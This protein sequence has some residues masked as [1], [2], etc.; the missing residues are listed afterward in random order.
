MLTLLRAIALAFL[1]VS[2]GCSPASS[3]EVNG[4]ASILDGDTLDIG[5]QRIRLFGIDAPETGQR[6]DDGKGKH[7]P[8]GAEA[9]KAL[10]SMTQGK[11]LRCEGDTRDTYGRLLARCSVA[12]VSINEEMIRQGMAWAFVKYSTDFVA[13]EADAKQARVGI[14]KAATPTAWEYRASRWKVAEVA[15]PNGCPI[16]G[17]VNSNGERIYH[18]PWSPWYEKV[19]MKDTG[20]GKRWFCSEE[21]AIAAGWRSAIWQ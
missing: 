2:S 4:R 12:S 10:R 8:C 20:K 1:A 6:C 19:N 21:E 5:T 14:W 15:A 17:N 11:E 7:W 13:L 9:A 3:E 16:K 18:P